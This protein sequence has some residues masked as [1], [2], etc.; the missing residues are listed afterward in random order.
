MP[1]VRHCIVIYLIF[2][3]TPVV[4]Y[5]KDSIFAISGSV[6]YAHSGLP[7]DNVKLVLV[8]SAFDT[9]F[10]DAE[11]A[12]KFSGLQAGRDYVVSPARAEDNSSISNFDASLILGYLAGKYELDN[13]EL[14]VADISGNGEVT[15]MDASIILKYVD[16]DICDSHSLFSKCFKD[17]SSS[18]F[19]FFVQHR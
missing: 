10:T 3:A 7:V 11:G 9:T 14:E 12:Y 19:L 13:L 1:K 5:T 17:F 16:C 8:G 4:S 6:S 18:V 2:I 15:A